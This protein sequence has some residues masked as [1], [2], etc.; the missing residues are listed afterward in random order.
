MEF[1]TAIKDPSE[2]AAK[3]ADIIN[4]N[5]TIKTVVAEKN[6]IGEVYISILKKLLKKPSILK[7]FTTTN[8]SKKKIIDGL[9][10][11]ISQKSITLLPNEQLQYEL[12]VYKLEP[13]K[14]GNYTYNGPKDDAIMST[15]FALSETGK[16]GYC[17][18]YVGY[19]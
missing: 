6:S 9:I 10:A 1:V 3:V 19:N 12:S 2:R 18:G 16:K 17:F 4:A 15:A 5:P 14:N 8:D 7:V 13:L 11:A